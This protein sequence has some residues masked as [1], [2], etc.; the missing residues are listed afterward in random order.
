MNSPV[1]IRFRFK[2]EAVVRGIIVRG[3]GSKKELGPLG[4]WAG[5]RRRVFRLIPLTII[6]LTL[7]ARAA[8]YCGTSRTRKRRWELVTESVMSG[9]VLVAMVRP[10][11]FFQPEAGKME[12]YCTW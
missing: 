6:P 12:L 11:R 4:C 1:R 2:A 7:P 10:P 3:M 5:M 9:R 8:G